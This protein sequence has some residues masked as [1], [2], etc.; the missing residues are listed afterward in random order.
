MSSHFF[1]N[2]WITQE[3]FEIWNYFYSGYFP[4]KDLNSS[5]IS[6]LYL[7]GYVG[8]LALSVLVGF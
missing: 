2:L 6:A 1:Y 5:Q 4:Q 7:S 8:G 3:I